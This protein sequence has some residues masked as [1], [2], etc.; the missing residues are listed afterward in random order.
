M[1]RRAARWPPDPAPAEAVQEMPDSKIQAPRKPHLPR[2]VGGS[3]GAS[4]VAPLC[5]WAAGE[6]WGDAQDTGE[7]LPVTGSRG[8]EGRR[9][10][11][12]RCAR[13]APA[14]RRPLSSP[15][16]LL[17]AAP[18]VTC[19]C[20]HTLHA[21]TAAPIPLV[22]PPHQ[23][24]GRVMRRNVSERRCPTGPARLGMLCIHCGIGQQR[25][26]VAATRGLAHL[27]HSSCTHPQAPAPTCR[28][29]HHPTARRACSTHLLLHRP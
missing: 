8:D 13:R 11:D 7:W 18:E 28:S 15:C 3:C 10:G 20:H 21:M 29:T 23:R 24:S 14:M 19:V 12:A 4:V 17:T 2:F 5:S 22:R 27:H 9:Q 25:S 26:G 6:A 16:H 1:F